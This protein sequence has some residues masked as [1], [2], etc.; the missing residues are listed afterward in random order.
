MT[1][2]AGMPAPVEESEYY[3]GLNEQLLRA[4]PDSARVIVE[5]GCAYGRLGARLKQLDPERVVF[6][7]ERALTAA[8][9]ARHVLDDVFVC[10]V[11]SEELPLERGSVDCILYGDVLEHMV[12]PGAVLERHRSLLSSSGRVVCSIPNLQ[13]HSVVT[14]LL[15]GDFQ[16]QESGLLDA[17]HLRFFT[18]A[19]AMKLLLDAGYAP[20]LVDIVEWAGAESV[21]EAGETLLRALR[22]DVGR[23]TKYMNAQQYIVTGRALE[24]VDH[25]EEVPITFVACVNDEAQL[26]DNLLRS[27][28]LR[29]PHPHEVLLFRGCASAA[30]GLNA[31]IEQ[32]HN[33][34][35]VLVHQDVYLPQGWTDR[36][37]QQW[38]AA[39]PGAERGGIAGV[40]GLDSGPHDGGFFGHVVDRDHLLSTDNKFPRPV[41]MIDEL[42]MVLP[43]GTPLRVDPDLGWHLYGTD[44]CLAARQLGLGVAVLDAI[45]HH[46]SLTG[47]V[48]PAYSQSED[49]IAAKWRQH[50]PIATI[51]SV[52]E[53]SSTQRRLAQL[54]ARTQQADASIGALVEERD[55]ARDAL[56]ESQLRIAAMEASPFWKLR[57]R[58]AAA[59]ALVRRRIS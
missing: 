41:D 57:Q 38:R 30:E 37:V 32:A 48:P 45:C 19:T 8:E 46:N 6:G 29:S 25:G 17:T 55:A 49:V 54:E 52:I 59:R 35:V 15:R 42:V 18:F 28:C 14:Q 16:Y 31:G 1:N 44:L 23:A 11:E 24:P 56:H 12:D 2:L 7:V 47:D 26:V 3:A 9:Q 10:D 34:L 27:P 53:R 40:W 4:V 20:D 5:V 50:L 36:L 43:R 22:V 51:C 39:F 58:Y 21:V 13:H 33:E